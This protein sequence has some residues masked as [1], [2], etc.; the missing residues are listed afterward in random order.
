MYASSNMTDDEV[1][2]LTGTLPAD[3]IA[4]LLSRV[5]SDDRIESVI[6][7]IREGSSSFLC[8]DFLSHEIERLSEIIAGYRGKDRAELIKIRDNLR[9]IENDVYQNGEYA[10]EELDQAIVC[11]G[12]GA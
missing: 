7:H 10:Q 9:D 6:V 2:R 12:E 4:A 5:F 1:F 3:R 8:E 11:L